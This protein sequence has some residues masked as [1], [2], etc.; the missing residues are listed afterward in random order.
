[1]RRAFRCG[2]S[3]QPA[4]DQPADGFGAG[5]GRRPSCV[6]LLLELRDGSFKTEAD[7]VHVLPSAR[8]R[9]GADA[10]HDGRT[11]DECAPAAAPATDWCGGGLRRGIVRLRRLVDAAVE[12]RFR[13]RE[14]KTNLMGR[15][16]EAL[17]RS[18]RA[19]SCASTADRVADG[20]A[21]VSPWS[22]RESP[23]ALAARTRCR[24]RVEPS[25]LP[26]SFDARAAERFRAATQVQRINGSNDS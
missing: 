21:F 2:R 8:A 17:R 12:V 26:A 6:V 7:V 24:D 9:A 16:D 15:V 19:E 13:E 3:V 22:F 25:R 18:G 20:D 23:A 11:S 10:R 14:R 4:A 1:M 5:L